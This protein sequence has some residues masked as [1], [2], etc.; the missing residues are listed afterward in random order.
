MRKF[1]EAE[2]QRRSRRRGF[3]GLAGGAGKLVRVEDL[4]GGGVERHAGGAGEAVDLRTALS[5]RPRLGVLTMRSKARSSAGWAMTG[6]SE[7]VPDLGAFVEAE[8]AD[9]AIGR[10]IAMKRSQ[11]PGLELG[12]HQDRTLSRRVPPALERLDLLADP[13]RFLR[14]S[15]TPT[16]VD[17]LALSCSVQSVLPSGRYSAR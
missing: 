4:R 9:D 12:A 7:R 13:P 10:P 3:Q 16:T 6:G 15:Q 1:V 2:R 11:L 14:P 5:P 17:L 8:A